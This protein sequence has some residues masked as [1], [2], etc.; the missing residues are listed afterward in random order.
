MKRNTLT[1]LFMFLL[2]GLFTL[3]CSDDS[4]TEVPEFGSISGTVS[5]TG[6][7]PAAGD[8]QVSIYAPLTPPYVPTGAPLAFTDPIASGV[9]T[10]DF[11]FEGLEKTEYGAIFVSWRDPANPAASKLLG[12]YWTDATDAGINVQTGLPTAQPSTITIDDD[13]IDV[14][15]ANLTANLDLAQ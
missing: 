15:G 8:I 5:F 2:F 3:S 14:T 11:N 9:N 10:Y 12:M 7:W 13:N 4:P 1:F 6:T